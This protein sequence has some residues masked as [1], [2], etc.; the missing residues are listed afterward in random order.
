MVPHFKETKLKAP[1]QAT[2]FGSRPATRPMSFF[3]RSSST[4]NGGVPLRRCA[5]HA[6]RLG[7]EGVILGESELVRTIDNG[8]ISWGKLGRRAPCKSRPRWANWHN[9]KPIIAWLESFPQLDERKAAQLA[10]KT[11]PRGRRRGGIPDAS[12][13][14]HVESGTGHPKDCLLKRKAF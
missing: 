14:K 4:T 1:S 8:L 11:H 7:G 5:V 12:R 6:K 3:H 13:A 10:T 9:E 2:A